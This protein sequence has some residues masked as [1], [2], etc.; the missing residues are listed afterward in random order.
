MAR[1]CK[2][3]SERARNVIM[4]IVTNAGTGTNVLNTLSRSAMGHLNPRAVLSS[5]ATKFREVAH[6]LACPPFCHGQALDCVP[7]MQAFPAHAIFFAIL[8]LDFSYVPF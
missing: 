7:R 2:S 6:L 1:H 4:W 5:A 8:Y 3:W